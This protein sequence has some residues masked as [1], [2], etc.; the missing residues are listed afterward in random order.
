L[1]LRTTVLVEVSGHRVES[2][3]TLVFVWFSTLVFLFYKMLFLIRLEF[4]CFADFFVWSFKTREEYIWFSVKSASR[5]DCE[6]HGAKNWSL[7]SNSCPI[8]PFLV[9][10]INK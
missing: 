8:I 9:W 10:C 6:Q 1:R 2:S 4:S 5:K 7:L 3:Q